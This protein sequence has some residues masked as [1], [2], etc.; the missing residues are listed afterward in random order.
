MNKI[1]S[2]KVLDDIY[3]EYNRKEFISPDP[4]EFLYHYTNNDDI[5]L[6]G[7]IASS[8]A[9]GNVKQI[10]KAI[11]S[12]LLPMGKSPYSFITESNQSYLEKKY[13]GFKYR[14][15]TSEDIILLFMGI[16]DVLKKE[17]NLKTCFESSIKES[18]NN[19]LLGSEVFINKIAKFFPN[20]ST[21]LLP[22]PS[23]GSACKRFNLFLR[24][25]IRK[26][27]VDFGLWDNK[28][29][30]QLIIPLDTHMNNI[31]QT[32]GISKYKSANLKAAIQ[33]TEYFKEIN[34]NDPVKY[35][36]ALTRFGIR[37]EMDI[38]E[39]LNMLK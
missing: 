19:L 29:S 2:K 30:E 22:K 37:A 27:N 17:K 31:C 13:N 35:D 28:L 12:I 25:M 32:T 39:I 15:T 33:I 36:F 18:N 16:K 34:P 20:N 11:N 38:K 21:Y 7:L 14:F 10:L 5:E 26:D 23:K 8:L 6:V 3:E 1:K 9:Y 24:W 4:L